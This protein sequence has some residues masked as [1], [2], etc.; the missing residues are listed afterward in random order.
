M[1]RNIHQKLLR[2]FHHDL[3]HHQPSWG[4]QIWKGKQW[5][6][7]VENSLLLS[8]FSFVKS[9]TINKYSRVCNVRKLFMFNVST[10]SE[11]TLMIKLGVDCAC[12]F[13][14]STISHTYLSVLHILCNLDIYPCTKLHKIVW[15]LFNFTLFI[16]AS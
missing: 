5:N 12:T 15:P 10:Y 1:L 3:T 14:Q 6:I 8:K 16:L 2:K 4:P 9:L 13:F 11:L 7:M